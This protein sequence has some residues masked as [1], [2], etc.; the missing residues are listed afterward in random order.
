MDDMPMLELVEP[1]DSEE[2]VL[3]E[4]PEYSPGHAVTEECD[5]LPWGKMLPLNS[6]R[7]VL[8]QLRVLASMLGIRVKATA[9]Q[10]RQLIEGKLIEMDREPRS[11]QVI[12]GEDSRLYLVDDAGVIQASEASAGTHSDHVPFNNELSDN[13]SE[14]SS[15]NDGLEALRSALREARL[16]N[17]RLQS[18][19]S[20]RNEELERL[21]SERD[22]LNTDKAELTARLSEGS[23]VELERLRAAVRNQTEK[24]KRF[25]RMRCEQILEHDELI[26]SKESEI[27]LL[28]AQL[29][30]SRS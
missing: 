18:Q 15:R 25:W 26:E 28:R 8:P 30:A 16:E 20:F 11:V 24:A 7:L 27:A 10:T 4:T 13:D 12:V 14:T 19:L 1:E 9:A 3:R 5:E 6:K 29:A 22:Q 21:C 2:Q 23:L 17:Q